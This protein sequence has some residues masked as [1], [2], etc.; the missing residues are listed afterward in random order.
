MKNFAKNVCTPCNSLQNM[1]TKN[2]KHH[3][4]MHAKNACKK[5]NVLHE[6]QAETEK[7]S[8]KCIQKQ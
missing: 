7:Y 4:K 3:K 2:T 5:N 8:E 6:I 1:Q